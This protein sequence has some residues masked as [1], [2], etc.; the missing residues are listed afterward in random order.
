MARQS[1]CS[2]LSRRGS[3]VA[4]II[5]CVPTLAPEPRSKFH[6]DKGLT[7][8]RLDKHIVNTLQQLTQFVND[9]Q[10]TYEQAVKETQEPPLQRLYRLLL[11][12]RAEFA[13]ELNQ[14]IQHHHGEPE[15][16]TSDRGQLYRQ[17]LDFKADCTMGKE[18]ALID[19]NLYGEEWAQKAYQQALEK[20][21]LPQSIRQILE[22]QRQACQQAYAQLLHLKGNGMRSPIAD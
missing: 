14:I 22:R 10:V 4:G 9:A 17:W 2:F 6:R 16:G 18:T 11:S 5:A 8:K 12:Q 13:T 19:L 1:G 21:D 20:E 7:M 3:A 15:T